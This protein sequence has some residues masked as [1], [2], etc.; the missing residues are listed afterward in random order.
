MPDGAAH[1][2]DCP[3]GSGIICRMDTAFPAQMLVHSVRRRQPDS[4]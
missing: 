3:A 2:R 4:A 1:S